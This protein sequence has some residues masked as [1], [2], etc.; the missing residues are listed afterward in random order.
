MDRSLY[1]IKPEAMPFN[2]EI[3]EHIGHSLAIVAIKS[4]LLPS[5][6]IDV[7]YGDLAGNLRIAANIALDGI[8]ELGLVQGDD[9]VQKLLEIAGKFTKPSDCHPNSLRYIYGVW[10]PMKLGEAE[11]YK[12]AIHRPRTDEEAILHINLFAKLNNQP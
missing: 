10:E 4:M 6:A 9:A 3:R 7:L 12:N 5:W 2:G 11:Y 8:I 1:M